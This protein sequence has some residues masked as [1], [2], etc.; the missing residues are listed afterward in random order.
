MLETLDDVPWSD[1]HHAYG[2][3]GDLPAQLRALLSGDADV[4]R[5]A[6]GECYSN[7]FH[8]G[9]R[10]EASSYAAPFLLEMLAS[11]STPERDELI[12]LLV[13]LAIGYDAPWLPHGLDSSSLK[14][15]EL[16]VHEAVSEGVP[17]FAR[18]LEDDDVAVRR[19]AA[20]ALGWFPARAVVSVSPL[21]W[22]LLDADE[23]VAATAA[24]A[25]GL[26]GDGHA[27]AS[28]V[29]EASFAGPRPLL[30][31]GAAI[32]LARLLGHDTPA[33]VVGE[34]QRWAADVEP[35]AA[36]GPEPRGVG[37]GAETGVRFYDGDLPGYASL[38]LRL[39]AKMP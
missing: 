35:P 27:P 16:R 7:I 1:I 24:I 22:A 2:P 38:A 31:A 21:A 34:L 19:S 17:L 36:P 25:L 37:P 29:L 6:Y 32:G 28:E 10:Y 11:P 3:A 23:S 18:L 26:I 9:T 33:E 15:V 8:Q 39:V 30:R 13:A 12:E 4:R 14:P 5:E 20:F